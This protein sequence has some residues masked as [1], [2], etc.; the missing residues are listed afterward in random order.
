MNK[1]KEK[2]SNGEHSIEE[3]VG[4]L[5]FAQ[6]TGDHFL[7]C[8]P[9]LIRLLWMQRQLAKMRLFLMVLAKSVSLSSSFQQLC[10]L[11]KKVF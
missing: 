9:D 4:K 2:Q 11:T 7:V 5:Y 10:Y 8:N 3:T 6:I 1:S